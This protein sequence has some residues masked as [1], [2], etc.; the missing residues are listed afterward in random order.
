MIYVNKCG[1]HM[2]EFYNEHHPDSHEC[3]DGCKEDGILPSGDAFFR[4]EK[5]M[6]KQT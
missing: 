1:F 6:K 4:F 5:V 3:H 2:V